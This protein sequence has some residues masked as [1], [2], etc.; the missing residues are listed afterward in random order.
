MGSG[1]VCKCTDHSQWR[2]LDRNC[3][4]SAFNGGH[5]TWSSYSGMLCL[6]CRC[7]WRSKSAYVRSTPDISPEEKAK[8][9][10]G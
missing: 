1:P 3:N 9:M 10:K 7:P 5:K 8:W 6:A 2:V 4:Y